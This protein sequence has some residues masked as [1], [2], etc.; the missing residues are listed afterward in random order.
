MSFFLGNKKR[1]WSDKSRNEEDA[2]KV[3]ENNESTGFLSDKVF[4]DGLNS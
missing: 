2:K 4:S 1:D 3:K